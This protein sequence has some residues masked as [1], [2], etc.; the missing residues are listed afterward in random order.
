MAQDSMSFESMQYPS[1]AGGSE[2]SRRWAA[3]GDRGSGWRHTAGRWRRRRRGRKGQEVHALSTVERVQGREGG[4]RRAGGAGGG[5]RGQEEQ[6]GGGGGRRSR[7][8]KEEAGGAGGAGRAYRSAVLEVHV[9]SSEVVEGEEG[10]PPFAIDGI[11]EAGLDDLAH[12]RHVIGD[13]AGERERVGDGNLDDPPLQ[14]D[15]L[16]MLPGV[17][18]LQAR[19]NGD[20]RRS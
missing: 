6:E 13:G 4:D 7:R 20:G 19:P 5:R 2:G 17:P 15:V 8:G 10:G 12:L 1:P 11:D 3:A 14:D 9:G 16:D 18:P